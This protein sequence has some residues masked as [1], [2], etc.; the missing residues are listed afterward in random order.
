MCC[1][2]FDHAEATNT[3]TS[4]DG[5]AAAHLEGARERRAGGDGL[6]GRQR[7]PHGA[8]RRPRLRQ[9]QRQDRRHRHVRARDAQGEDTRGGSVHLRSLVQNS[10]QFNH[11]E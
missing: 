4:G 2:T 3:T 11:R 6:R 9:P 7:G 5:R 1:V 10:K 8:H